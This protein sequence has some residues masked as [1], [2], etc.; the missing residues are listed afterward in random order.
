MK[1]ITKSILGILLLTSI[2]SLQSCSSDDGNSATSNLI[3]QLIQGCYHDDD[4]DGKVIRFFPDNTLFILK[5]MMPIIAQ[6]MTYT[7]VN[8][9]LK[10]KK[11][12]LFNGMMKIGHHHQHPSLC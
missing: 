3:A 8:G 6:V 7:S 12:L 1:S 11:T 4:D 9:V 2:F 5:I 10:T